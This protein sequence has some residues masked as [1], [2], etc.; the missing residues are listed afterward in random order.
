MH[1]DQP[2][3]AAAEAVAASATGEAAGLYRQQQQDLVAA[4]RQRRRM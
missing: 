4:N 3:R 2:G 1:P